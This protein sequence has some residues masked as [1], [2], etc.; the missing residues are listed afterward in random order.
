[1]DEIP[2]AELFVVVFGS[3]G[4]LALGICAVRFYLWTRRRSG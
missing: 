3:I 1:M 4:L 2:I